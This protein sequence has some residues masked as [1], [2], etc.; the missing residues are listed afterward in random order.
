MTTAD[1]STRRSFL[2]TAG[3]ALSVPLA[4]VAASVPA[5]AEQGADPQA[6]LRHL[7]DERAIRA[8]QQAYAR[9]LNG[10]RADDGTVL[11]CES[12]DVRL[13]S[14]VCAVV[15]TGFGEHDVIDIDPGGQFATGLLHCS[16]RIET[17]IG[18]NCPLV[19][20][21][22]AQGG[23]VLTGTETGVFEQR[24]VRQD[25]GWRIQRSVYRTV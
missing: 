5:H 4:G 20:M 23:G 25:G 2:R 17:T 16:V 21:A 3:T 11:F 8:L 10:D 13:E 1:R 12:A 6:R 15:A 19:E 18:P 24:Y 9:H 14:G 7:E 22:R